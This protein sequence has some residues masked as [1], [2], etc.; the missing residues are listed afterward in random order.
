MIP[1]Y[2]LN[3]INKY[4]RI[5]EVD[6]SFVETVHSDNIQP[7]SHDIVLGCI[8][9]IEKINNIRRINKFHRE[10]FK[11]LDNEGIYLS[12]VETISQ[13]KEKFKNKIPFGLR[14]LFHLIDF[15]FKRVIP[16]LPITKQ[17][18]FAITKG[19]NR[20]LS[21]AEAL[22]R[23]TFCGFTI[24]HTFDYENKFYIL[25]VKNHNL[26]NHSKPSYGPLIAL[27]RVG[28]E[29]KIFKIYKFRTMHP[30][31]E[32]IQEEVFKQNKLNDKGKL[33]ND[34][35]LTNW[36]KFFRKYWIDEL[37]QF[38]NFLKG[39][40]VLIGPRALS[41]HF[42]SLYPKDLQLLRTS[43]RPGLIP[44]YYADMPKNFDEI[45]QS[46]RSFLL[47]KAKNPNL[48]PIKYFF[49]SIFNIIIKGARSS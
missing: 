36:G 48:T 40:V 26:I 24:K 25:A 12:C 42:F 33:S 16:K 21:K 13:R 46:E 9:N 38:L 11:L 22:G 35:R 14:K 20:V 43:I 30:Y 49:K 23:L 7:T 31:S 29:K 27:D 2:I 4:I 17:I 32:F 44:P 47:K 6:Y 18:Y 45:I 34:F 5:D 3:N 10:V 37:P 19:N 8:I 15:I 28:Y 41:K 39:D 1:D